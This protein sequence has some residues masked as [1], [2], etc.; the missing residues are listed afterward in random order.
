[1]AKFRAYGIYTASIMIGEY[2][3]DNEDQAMEMSQDDDVHAS[4]CHHC[5]QNIELNPEPHDFEIVEVD[6]KA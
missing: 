2:E 3:A 6:P 1:M 5:A 4:L